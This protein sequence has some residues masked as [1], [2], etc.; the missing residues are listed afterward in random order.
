[1]KMS[2]IRKMMQKMAVVTKRMIVKTAYQFA[3]ARVYIFFTYVTIIIETMMTM[4]QAVIMYKIR[5]L[6]LVYFSIV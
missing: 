4:R 1:M 5:R 6:I 2:M 3:C